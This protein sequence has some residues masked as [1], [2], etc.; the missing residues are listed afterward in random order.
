LFLDGYFTAIEMN[1]GQDAQVDL[2][3][4][5]VAVKL[6]LLTTLWNRAFPVEGTAGG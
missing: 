3:N 5:R 6:N 2:P 4:P 1:R